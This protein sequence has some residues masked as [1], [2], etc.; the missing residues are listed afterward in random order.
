MPFEK[1]EIDPT[2]IIDGMSEEEL[3]KHAQMLNWE[4]KVSYWFFKAC[5]SAG[6]KANKL[7]QHILH[8]YDTCEYV[9]QVY[10]RKV[11]RR[12]MKESAVLQKYIAMGVIRDSETTK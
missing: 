10:K 3:K 12:L 8:L 11:V 1:A 5:I 9:H 7:G 2:S 6:W 4:I